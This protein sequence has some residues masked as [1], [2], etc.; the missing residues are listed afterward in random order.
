MRIH[1][2]L[3]IA[4]ALVALVCGGFSAAGGVYIVLAQ[5][6][7]A[8]LSGAAILQ[9]VGVSLL[10]ILVCVGAASWMVMSLCEPLWELKR[11]VQNVRKTNQDL[12]VYSPARNEIGELA[13]EVD[14]LRSQLLRR[15]YAEQKNAKRLLSLSRISSYLDVVNGVRQVCN[16]ALEIVM[17]ELGMK[18]GAVYLLD[19]TGENLD[20]NAHE[21]LPARLPPAARKYPAALGVIGRTVQSGQV[22][23]SDPDVAESWLREVAPNRDDLAQ[24]VTIPLGSSSG[25]QGV[26]VLG[27]DKARLASHED[28]EMLTAMGSQIGAAIDNARTLQ[29]SQHNLH[30]IQGLLNISQEVARSLNL[31]A[32]LDM[33]LMQAKQL[34]EVDTC[35]IFRV[36]S[37]NKELRIVRSAGLNPEYVGS[38]CLKIGEGTAGRAVSER[39]P[40]TI[41]DAAIDPSFSEL[42]MLVRQEGYYSVLAVPLLGP[43]RVFGAIE[44]YSPQRRQFQEEEVQLL[45]IFANQVSVAIANAE[46]HESATNRLTALNALFETVGFLSASSD[47]NEIMDMVVNQVSKLFP[48]NLAYIMLEHSSSHELEVVVSRGFSDR[49]KEQ[50]VDHHIIP[51]RK[52]WALKKGSQFVVEDDKRDF[53]CPEIIAEGPAKSY[54]CAPLSAGGKTFGVMHMSSDESHRFAAEDIDLFTTLANQV[55]ISVERAQLFQRVEQLAITDPLTELHNYRY[56]RERLSESLR[57]AKRNERPVSLLMMDLDHFKQHNDTFGHPSGDGVLRK[58]AD[59][60]RDSLREVDFS[61]R[62]GGE[63]FTVILHDTDK[64]GATAVAEKIRASIEKMAFFGDNS[65]PVVHRTISI[66]IAA[67]PADASSDEAL[68]NEADAALYRAKELGRNRV[69]IAGNVG[70]LRPVAVQPGPASQAADVESRMDRGELSR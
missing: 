59:V 63:E 16:A 46:L 6:G 31:Q 10:A 32:V 1:R 13:E 25:N 67:F 58:L 54:A 33:I 60:V 19:E 14:E 22:L 27:G 51:L 26:M 17:R 37:R 49:C 65:S 7:V 12:E 2:K 21:G 47:P 55:A 70:E 8:R 9:V 57:Y 62:Y 69:C 3:I 5:G 43:D 28:I 50:H 24:I 66:G 18:V 56:F 45:S 11:R 23:Y 20:L 39:R 41:A 64:E 48:C 38:V 15:I 42:E 35:A 52:C 44:V 61:A 36:D 4:Y 34:I 29:H 53:A 30:H 68:I 40:I